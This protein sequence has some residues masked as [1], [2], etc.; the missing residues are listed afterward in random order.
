MIQ[1][2]KIAYAAGGIDIPSLPEE[3]QVALNQVLAGEIELTDFISQMN[4]FQ[5]S[6]VY[7]KFAPEDVVPEHREKV[8]KPLWSRNIGTLDGNS[9]LY[10]GFHTSSVQSASSGEYYVDVYNASPNLIDQYGPLV[11]NYPYLEAD[12]DNFIDAQPQFAVA[13]GH[14]FGHGSKS[15]EATDNSAA[16]AIYS[17][18]RNILLDP[19]DE[20]FTFDS[21]KT[22]GGDSDRIFIVNVNRA[23][24]KEK[25]D[26]GNWELKLGR[27]KTS[28]GELFVTASDADGDP[29]SIGVESGSSTTAEQWTVFG[30]DGSSWS[31]TSE[32]ASILIET[33]SGTSLKSWLLS[34]NLVDFPAYAGQAVGTATASYTVEATQP[35]FTTQESEPPKH[36]GLYRAWRHWTHEGLY[37]ELTDDS[38]S[39]VSHKIKAGQRVFNIISGSIESEAELGSADNVDPA[40]SKNAY[41][42][43]YPD[44]GVFCFN[45]NALTQSHEQGGINL[46]VNDGEAYYDADGGN[47]I[48]FF[49][50]IREGYK[51][52]ARSEETVTSTHFFCRIKNKQYNFSNNPTFYTASDGS[53]T[54]D[55]FFKNPRSYITTVGLYNDANELLAVAKLSRPLL[56]SFDREAVVKVKLD[57]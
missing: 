32:K 26:P 55:D 10:K 38:K 40:E 21:T 14:Y 22:G 33:G 29:H 35:T 50:A 4:Q 16:K 46:T 54:N 11:Q 56:K 12:R 31:G 45:G 53:F 37:I 51:F 34:A 52:Q 41:G 3:I 20:K 48:I 8:S 15:T 25:L 5:F 39:Q 27:P 19:T 36:T 7:T 42:L 49:E 9:T 28:L 1:S 23:R 6:G 57:F 44:I 47:D 43:F 30:E 13:F 2:T 18:Y 24:Y 17:Q